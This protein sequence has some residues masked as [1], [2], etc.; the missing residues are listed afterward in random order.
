MIPLK[1]ALQSAAEQLNAEENQR[2][3]VLMRHGTM[4]IEY[5]APKD[6]D[7]Q[8][9]HAQDEIYIIA[10]GSGTFIRGDEKVLFSEGD[11]LFVPAGM[12]H[13][14]EEFT[15]DFATWVVFYGPEGGESDQ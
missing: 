10:T 7:L 12:D 8:K 4:R 5:Y 2:F 11:M 13:R 9:P 14:F 15:S 6:I 3:T 1:L